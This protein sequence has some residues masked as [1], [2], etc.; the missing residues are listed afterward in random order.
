MKVA[1]LLVLLLGASGC[2]YF[3]GYRREVRLGARLRVNCRDLPE[4]GTVEERAI[5]PCGG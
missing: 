4:L 5:R 2:E 3:H 1:A